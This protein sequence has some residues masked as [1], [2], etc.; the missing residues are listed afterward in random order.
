MTHKELVINKYR[1]AQQRC[2]GERILKIIQEIMYALYEQQVDREI[3]V[4]FCSVVNVNENKSRRQPRRYS[5]CPLP[6]AALQVTER[7]Q[8][9]QVYELEMALLLFF[10]ARPVGTFLRPGP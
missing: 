3:L 8:S 7:A 9:S 4:A 1:N 2:S 5:C 6:A 10:W